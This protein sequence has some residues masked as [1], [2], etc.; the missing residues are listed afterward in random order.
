MDRG[1]YLMGIATGTRKLEEEGTRYHRPR[2]E[3]IAV[4]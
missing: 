3:V 4:K 1:Y 2:Q